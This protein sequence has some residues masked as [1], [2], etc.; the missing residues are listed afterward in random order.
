[1]CDTADG[2]FGSFHRSKACLIFTPI[3][4]SSFF[5]FQALTSTAVKK[6]GL[7]TGDVAAVYKYKNTLIDVKLDTASIVGSF[8]FRRLK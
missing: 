7:S 6:G 8:V 4:A 3:L 2:H 1:M 5:S